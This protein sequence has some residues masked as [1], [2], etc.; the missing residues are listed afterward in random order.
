MRMPTIRAY[1]DF[2][3][4]IN[5]FYTPPC[6]QTEPVHSLISYSMSIIDYIANGHYKYLICKAKYI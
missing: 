1:Y 6:T 4:G 5:N 2:K 3:N